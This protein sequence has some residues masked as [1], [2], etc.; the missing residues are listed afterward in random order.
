[1][2]NEASELAKAGEL[3]KK[4]MF[5]GASKRENPSTYINYELDDADVEN[6]EETNRGTLTVARTIDKARNADFKAK[7]KFKHK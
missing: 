3:E 2:G 1:M 7:K 4:K 6:A 5:E